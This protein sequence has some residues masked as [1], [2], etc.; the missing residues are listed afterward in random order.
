MM[1]FGANPDLCAVDATTTSSSGRLA[2]ILRLFRLRVPDAIDDEDDG[3]KINRTPSSGCSLC[4]GHP[5]V[6]RENATAVARFDS[7]LLRRC[8]FYSSLSR[9]RRKKRSRSPINNNVATISSL[10]ST[11]PELESANKL[12]LE[13]LVHCTLITLATVVVYCNAVHGDFVHDDV[14][15]I[16]TNK[17]ALGKSPVLNLLHNDFWGMDIKDRYTN[18]LKK[19][20]FICPPLKKRQ[21]AVKSV[22]GSFEGEAV[23]IAHLSGATKD[24]SLVHVKV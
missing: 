21:L 15:A 2:N 12:N 22:C 13:N 19:C 7:S 10:Q 18:A 24:T 8:T 17:D 14:A 6:K 5:Q 4:S 3:E 23:P 11:S 1:L 20:G 9:I 16:V